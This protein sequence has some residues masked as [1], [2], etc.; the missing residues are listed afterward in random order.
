MRRSLENDCRQLREIS[1]QKVAFIQKLED[2]NTI[3]I[4]EREDLSKFDIV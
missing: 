1:F 4:R 2:D 3:V